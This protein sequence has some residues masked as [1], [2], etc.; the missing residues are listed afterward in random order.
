MDF[1]LAVEKS[2]EK[3]FK[4]RNL[5]RLD[6]W[7][8]LEMAVGPPYEGK[9]H[10]IF[11]GSCSLMMKGGQERTSSK[12]IH[13]E[14]TTARSRDIYALFE[15]EPPYSLTVWIDEEHCF[16]RGAVDINGLTVNKDAAT[17]YPE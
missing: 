7:H 15:F 16:G 17:G 14:A 10:S 12:P 9:G 3:G 5:D 6:S 8:L 11:Q 2:L 1:S 13:L 4:A